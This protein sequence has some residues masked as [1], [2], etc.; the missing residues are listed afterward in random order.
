MFLSYI[1]EKKIVMTNVFPHRYDL[2]KKKDNT[3]IK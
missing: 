3:V 1:E 2:C